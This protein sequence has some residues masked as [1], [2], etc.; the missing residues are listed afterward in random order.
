MG[1]RWRWHRANGFTAAGLAI[2]RVLL[3][4]KRSEA[5][6]GIF[7]YVGDRADAG[8]IVLG[9]LRK[10]E[11]ERSDV[12]GIAVA[13]GG[14]PALERGAGKVGRPKLRLPRG[15]A[16]VGVTRAAASS[17]LQIA[18]SVP[19]LADGGRFAV[20]VDSRPSRREVSNARDEYADAPELTQDLGQLARRFATHFAEADAGPERL[21]R[22]AIAAIAELRG[23]CALV[24]L[25]VHENRIAAVKRATPL[26]IGW[27]VCGTMIASDYGPL[28]PYTR[29][30]TFVRDHEA[31]LLEKEGCRL[32]DVATGVE[33]DAEV[34]QLHLEGWPASLTSAPLA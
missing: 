5:M 13:T 31:V 16:G 4:P 19:M 25:D 14:R 12:W 2:A 3:L 21:A 20:I 28:K 15:Y 17:G 22:A 18:E 30:V 7:G 24:A 10:L 1:R 9:A 11:A 34:T 26:V 6:C 27:S 29:E 32:L 8:E 33:T 23:P